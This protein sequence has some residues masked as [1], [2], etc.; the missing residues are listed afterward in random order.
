MTLSPVPK[1]P[2]GSA[3]QVVEVGR[4]PQCANLV[5]ACIQ[6]QKHCVQKPTIRVVAPADCNRDANKLVEPGGRGC[7]SRRQVGGQAG[8]RGGCPR[9]GTRR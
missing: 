9:G 1:A 3:K 6:L 5:A 4:A 7:G 8:G 2:A